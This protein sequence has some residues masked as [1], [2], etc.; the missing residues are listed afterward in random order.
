[1]KPFLSVV[2]LALVCWGLCSGCNQGA[3]KI[4]LQ[5]AVAT[6]NLKAVQ[7]HIVAKSDLNQPDPSGWTPLQVAARNGNVGIVK[8]L[9]E[10]GADVNRKGNGGLTAL[11]VA[12]QKGRTEVVQY[13]EQRGAKGSKP[14][15]GLI[16]GGLGVSEVLDNP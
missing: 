5:N 4:S 15:R 1:M 9:T 8:A 2:F 12:R 6:G 3:P 16:D 14:G 7:Q 13:F 11:Q 10:A